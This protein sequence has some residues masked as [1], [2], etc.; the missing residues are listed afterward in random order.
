MIQY[1]PLA[2]SPDIEVLRWRCPG[3]AATSGPEATDH[4]EVVLPTHGC[5]LRRSAGGRHLADP[6]TALF[7]NLGEEYCVSHP[8]GCGDRGV[9]LKLAP[10][11]VEEV[12]AVGWRR[13]TRSS[14]L[15]FPTSHATLDAGAAGLL[16]SLLT[17]LDRG[18]TAAPLAVEQY[19]LALVRRLVS[20]DP[21]DGHQRGAVRDRVEAAK[22]ILAARFREAISLTDLARLVGGSPFRVA[23]EFKAVTGVSPHRWQ[24]E[25]RLKAA[26]NLLFESQSTIATIALQTGFSSHSHLTDTM[27]RLTGV[28]PAAIRQG[29]AVPTL[30]RSGAGPR[31]YLGSRR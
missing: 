20:R 5:F 14:A 28:S 21:D 17:H 19:A 4:F 7:L 30:F 3:A 25:L 10:A 31:P 9:V 24:V 13:D 18:A 22:A 2:Q 23:R 15:R 11:L 8:D 27:G 29:R 6:N 16:P 1:D 12:L 26:L